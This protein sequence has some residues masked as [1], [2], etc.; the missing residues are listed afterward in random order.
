MEIITLLGVILDR[1]AFSDDLSWDSED[2]TVSVTLPA[3]MDIDTYAESLLENGDYVELERSLDYHSIKIIF[4]NKRISEVHFGNEVH[5]VRDCVDR[6]VRD[7]HI[8]DVY[9]ALCLKIIT[10]LTARS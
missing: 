6:Y 3:C 7:W 5:N 9:V 10:L 2:S 1:V 8:E 4:E